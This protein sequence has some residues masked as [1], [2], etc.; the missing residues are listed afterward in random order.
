M[1]TPLAP[2]ATVTQIDSESLQW[3]VVDDTTY[4]NGTSKPTRAQC[5]VNFA[6]TYTTAAG[7]VS[8]VT[9]PSYAEATV[10]TVLFSIIGDGQV[11]VVMTIVTDPAGSWTG[12]PV[13]VS[14]EV[15]QLR[16]EDLLKCYYAELAEMIANT[17]CGC[18]LDTDE[19]E[20]V[21]EIF[22]ALDSIE[23]YVTIGNNFTEALNLMSIAQAMCDEGCGC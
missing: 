3:K 2:V 12:V 10:E 5:L 14:T 13:S 17:K 21:Y 20:Y 9:L 23:Y 11:S 19:Y 1:A 7:V 4:G 8:T 18:E 15:N 6:V 22:R 16:Q